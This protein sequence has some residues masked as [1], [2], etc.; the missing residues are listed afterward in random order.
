MNKYRHILCFLFLFILS[1]TGA[2]NPSELHFSFKSFPLLQQLP[3]GS[4]RCVFEDKEG[5]IWLGTADGLCRYDAYRVTVFRSDTENGRLLSN[6]DVLCLEE[7]RDGNLLI[8]TKAGLN[9]FSIKDYSFRRIVLPDLRDDEIRK[10]VRDKNG[11]LWIGTH[12]RLLRLSPDLTE[13][14][15][16]DTSLPV[17]SVND[18]YRDRDDNIW[19]TFWRK[20]IYRYN[21]EK[22]RF[23]KMP[24]IGP[25]NNPF[26]V[27]QDSRHRFWVS[28]WGDGI[29]HMYPQKAWD[30]IF[31]KANSTSSKTDAKHLSIIFDIVEDERYGYLWMIGNWGMDIL[32]TDTNGQLYTLK[33]NEFNE[34]TNNIFS[35]IYKTRSGTLWISAFN[36]GAY[37]IDLDVPPIRNYDFPQIKESLNL[38]TNIRS[39]LWLNENELLFSQS[40]WGLGFFSS[41]NGKVTF[42]DQIAGLKNLSGL[43]AVACF[44]HFPS[45]PDKVWVCPEFRTYVHILRKEENGGYVCEHTYNLG[46]LQG[47]SPRY[48]IYKDMK[49]NVW[50]GTDRGIILKSAH[51]GQMKKLGIKCKGNASSIAEDADGNIWLGYEEDGMRKLPLMGESGMPD[52]AYAEHY[53][54]DN[55]FLPSNHVTALCTTPAY[56]WIGTQ[57]GH[58]IKYNLKKKTSEPIALNLNESIQ[59]IMADTIG[60]IWIATNRQVIEYNPRTYGSFTYMAGNGP[61]VN[62]FS[63]KS[64]LYTEATNQMWFGGNHG[65]SGFSGYSKLAK[66]PEV[67]RTLI[68]DIK[69]NG[70]SV[71]QN[72]GAGCEWNAA[73]R[74]IRFD[75]GV[76]DIELDFSAR[77]YSYPDKILYAYRIKGIDND[78]IYTNGTRQFAY[79]NYLPKGKYTM[80]LRA[81]DTNGRWSGRIVTYTLFKE[82]AFYETWYA[83]LFYALVLCAILYGLYFKA[84]RR[85]KLRNELRIAQIQKEKSEELTQT[86]LRYFTNVSH[87]FLTPISVVSCLVDDIEMTYTSKIPQL[88]QIRFNMGKLKKLIQQI[89]DFRKIEYGMMKLNVTQ[90]DIVE[91]VRSVCDNNFAVLLD[92]KHV[93]FS[94]TAQ[95]DNQEGFFDED[96]IEKV[97]DNLLSNAVKYTP[98]NGSI[99]VSVDRK[100]TDGHV[101]AEIKVTDSGEGISEENLEKIF[102]RFYIIHRE[103]TSRSNGIGLSL[104][105]DMLDLHHASINVESHIGKG[106]TFTIML[107]VDRESYTEDEITADKKLEIKDRELPIEQKELETAIENDTETK[108]HNLLLVEDNEE[109]LSVMTRILSRRYYIFQASDGEQAWEKVNTYDIDLIISDVAMPNMDGLE[110]C[111]KLKNDLNVSHI[112]FIMLTARDSTEDRIECYNA[113]ADGYISKPFELKVLEARISNFLQNREKRQN[114]FRNNPVISNNK[115]DMSKIDHEF[116]KKLVTVI[117]TTIEDPNFDIQR[118]ASEV[119]MSK[120]SLYR[121]VKLLTGLSPVEF[122]RNTKLKYAARLLLE[123]GASIVEVADKSGFS[124]SK[125]FATCFKEEFELTPTEYQK[126]YSRH[127]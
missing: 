31:E 119:N 125:Y 91:F 95:P 69:I 41:R 16:Y 87:D 27:F 90:G 45:E 104:V 80:E 32:A 55:S 14:K 2:A 114:E 60:N 17:T 30:D 26:K 75:S 34:K 49:G 107:P 115:L 61:V 101:W 103:D 89:L 40:R 53:T 19:V 70:K 85:M 50:I 1:L 63:K 21:S 105:K 36:E 124:N 46:K 82:P 54:C 121:K 112:P 81:T 33:S 123:P 117:E 109:L 78:W 74:V 51:T 42:Y 38:T 47:G 4:V 77:N 18:I 43:D 48:F 93:T 120:S 94:F 106:T 76:K 98:E 111:R 29:Y 84:A 62:S 108:S 65:I 58:L 6:N 92:K 39:F 122:V 13:C 110:L 79:Y 99:S 83:M 113:G 28:T 7:D 67:V 97:V 71:L 35:H 88:K 73:K 24:P 96:K 11:F 116:I 57:E 72:G 52:S 23:E 66:D 22:D 25:D 37:I 64:C 10:I 86:K 44:G 126:R 68:T 3:S 100:I 59:D 127:K 9:I 20:G 12:T 5:I 102:T 56:L 8:G 118:L 15:R